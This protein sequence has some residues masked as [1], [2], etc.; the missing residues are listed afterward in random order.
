MVCWFS[1]NE[2]FA[3]WHNRPFLVADP[4]LSGKAEPFGGFA[5]LAS[6]ALVG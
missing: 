2:T 3:I 6:Q 1:E 4:G 5:G